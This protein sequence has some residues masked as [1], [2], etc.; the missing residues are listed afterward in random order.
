MISIS[1]LAVTDSPRLGTYFKVGIAGTLR[2]LT[3]AD[4]SSDTVYKIAEMYPLTSAS[5]VSAKNSKLANQISSS[6]A[7]MISLSPLSRGYLPDTTWSYWKVG[8]RWPTPNLT[9]RNPL[10]TV[11][12]KFLSTSP[13][14]IIDMG[15]G[16]VKIY[17]NS[18]RTVFTEFATYSQTG[19]GFDCPSPYNTDTHVY[20]SSDCKGRTKTYGTSTTT[21]ALY[22][23]VALLHCKDG[24]MSNGLYCEPSPQTILK[25]KKPTGWPCELIYDSSKFQF[26]F[27]YRN[28]TCDSLKLRFTNVPYL[29]EFT[30]AGQKTS[31]KPFNDGTFDVCLSD[32]TSRCVHTLTY[33]SNV[34][35]YPGSGFTETSIGGV[36]QCGLEGQAA[37]PPDPVASAPTPPASTPTPPAS[38]PKPPVVCGAG[39]DP[40]TGLPIPGIDPITGLPIPGFDPI[41]GLPIPDA[42]SGSAFTSL[43]KDWRLIELPAIS[44][45]ACSPVVVDIA[46]PLNIHVSADAHCKFYEDHESLII[47]G[48]KLMWMFVSVLIVMSA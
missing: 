31:I 46:A 37:C 1:V 40:I 7:V 36:S 39:C 47:W 5:T 34:G 2:D 9:Y 25:F 38:A 11:Y 17:E 21:G 15:I 33:Q 28:V 48:E 35:G 44:S 42:T 43:L 10:E 16:A 6:Q 22:S 32:T 27:D 4:S 12:P 13:L 30:S 29:L 41:T 23:R 45:A 24:Y 20:A 19:I 14:T 18:N 3:F 26:E 8:D